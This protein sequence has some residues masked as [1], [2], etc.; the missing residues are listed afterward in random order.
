MPHATTNGEKN[1][2]QFLDHLTSLPAVSDGIETFKTNPYGKKSLEVTNDAYS[3]FGKPVEPY[4]K[5]PYS[6]AEPYI[7][8]ADELA[9]SGLSHVE[10]HFPIITK[11][12]KTIIETT[13]SYV[14]AP[15]RYVTNTYG[16][17][18]VKTAKYNGRGEGMYTRVLAIISTEMKIASDFFAKVSEVLGPKYEDSKQKVAEYADKVKDAAD[19]YSKEGQERL[20]KAAKEGQSKLDDAQKTGEKKLDQAKG[21][22]KKAG[23]KAEAKTQEVK[24]DAKKSTK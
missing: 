1:S 23:D 16:D 8:K 18:Y 11:D 22:A 6:Y 3:R 21:D 24:E 2:S 9:D 7:Q 20:E 19:H 10:N 13:K 12:T 4:L 17:E 14:F 15:L 5:T